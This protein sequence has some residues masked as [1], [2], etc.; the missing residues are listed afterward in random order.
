MN[1]IQVYYDLAK[2]QTEEQGKR[3]QHLSTMAIGLLGFSAALI[4]ITAVT[5]DQWTSSSIWI[6]VGALIGFL[7]VV[8]SAIGVLRPKIW[9]KQ[10]P[11]DTFRKH[12]FD[13]KYTDAELISWAAKQMAGAVNNNEAK[14]QAKAIRLARAYV[15]LGME[16]LFLVGLVFATAA[17]F[18]SR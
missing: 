11:L 13:R 16:V 1:A 10:P 17:P 6:A 3:R 18:T 14:L 2:F 9:D 5:S 7:F 12:I 15:G 8:V 4:A